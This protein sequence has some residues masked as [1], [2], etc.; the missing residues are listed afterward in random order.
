[1]S[2]KSKANKFDPCPCQSGAVYSKCCAPFHEHKILP[3]TAMQLM[4]SRYCAYALKNAPYIIETTDKESPLRM[5][6]LEKWL[7]DISAFSAATRFNGLKI[8]EHVPE[9]DNNCLS[10]VTFHAFLQS[11]A[12][13]EDM[14]FI[15]KSLF[16]K[17][18][19]RW[20]YHSGEHLPK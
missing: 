8:V 12:N 9:L 14:S 2:T 18:D 1:M 11:A 3:E 4:R 7:L 15:E 6:S 17:K 10:Y 19:G 20:Y 13:G 16:Y 5:D